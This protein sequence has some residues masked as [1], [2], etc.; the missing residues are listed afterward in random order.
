MCMP[1][2]TRWTPPDRRATN[3]IIW[4]RLRWCSPVP[5]LRQIRRLRR[6]SYEVD[7]KKRQ[8]LTTEEG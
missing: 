2:S 5:G 1:S 4:C 6:A 7:E 3:L 8:V